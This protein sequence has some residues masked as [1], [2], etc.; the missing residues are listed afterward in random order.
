MP[1]PFPVS[2]LVGSLSLP[3]PIR[4]SHRQL[5]PFPKPLAAIS[6]FLTS[7]AFAAALRTSD[8]SPALE[9]PPSVLP[10]AFELI[11]GGTEAR[12]FEEGDGAEPTVRPGWEN[13]SFLDSLPQ[14]APIFGR[15]GE[16]AGVG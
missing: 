6:P 16:G 13:G 2:P 9:G 10:G 8:V 7:A 11:L 3:S 5:I 15:D 4:P 1:N 14:S 12:G